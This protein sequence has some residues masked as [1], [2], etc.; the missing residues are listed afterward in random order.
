MF[1]I[2]YSPAKSAMQAGTAKEDVC[3]LKFDQQ[4]AK[5][6]EPLMGYTSSIDTQG[7]VCLTFP[8]KEHAI[9]FAEK[10]AIPYRVQNKKEMVRAKLSYA[11]N[12]HPE[13]K[14]PWTH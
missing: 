4:Y 2:I 3:L 9:N 6:I 14:R 1:A 11:D 13:R 7:Q 10:N 8:S 12:F 5:M